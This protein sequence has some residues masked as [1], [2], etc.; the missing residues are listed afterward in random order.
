MRLIVL[1]YFSI[2]STV[3]SADGKVMYLANEGLMV[4][5]G[6][7]KVLFDPIFR[8]SYDTYQLVPPEIEDNLLAGESIAIVEYDDVGLGGGMGRR[9]CEQH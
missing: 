3:A 9:R 4:Q 1:A 8:N 5:A 7:S 6:D 2:L